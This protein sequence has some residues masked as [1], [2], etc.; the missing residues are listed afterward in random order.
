MRKIAQRL[1]DY[2]AIG[3]EASE[4]NVS[5]AFRVCEKLRR[6]L[7]QFAG[8][9]GFRSLISRALILAK[10]EVAW[11]EEL[12]LKEDGSL[13]NPG[14]KAQRAKEEIARGEI[15]LVAQLLGLLSTFIGEALTLRLLQEVWPGAPINDMDSTKEKEE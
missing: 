15:V 7:K 2:E 5:A 1:I 9:T 8:D 11:L 12:R 10:A 4:A 3:N 13:E 6:L 14:T